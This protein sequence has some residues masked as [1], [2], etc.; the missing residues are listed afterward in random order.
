MKCLTPKVS[1][2]DVES[3]TGR[4]AAAFELLNYMADQKMPW[5]PEMSQLMIQSNGLGTV[6]RH[7]Q[8]KNEW[9][10]AQASRIVYYIILNKELIKELRELSGISL[11]I[12]NLDSPNRTI[13]VGAN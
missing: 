3:S 9:Q 12:I 10:V 11:L 6:L 8:S 5:T 1:G 7:L 13:R 4:V 2:E